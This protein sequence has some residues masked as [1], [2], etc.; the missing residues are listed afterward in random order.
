MTKQ[1]K[2][3]KTNF[4]FWNPHGH[5][6]T[7]CQI[8]MFAY[9]S[10]IHS[11]ITQRDSL[12]PPAMSLSAIILVT[13]SGQSV[14]KRRELFLSNHKITILLAVRLSLTSPVP[15]LFVNVNMIRQKWTWICCLRLFKFPIRLLKF[16]QF[17]VEKVIYQKVE[18][19]SV[20][21]IK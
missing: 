18:H 21:T 7:E 15:E 16:P 12:K 20:T 14:H 8:K 4:K 3:I 17:S 2:Q 11:I 5:E 19:V 10:H 13:Q 9:S 1:F 6:V